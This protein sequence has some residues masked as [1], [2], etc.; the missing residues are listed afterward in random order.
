MSRLANDVAFLPTAS[1]CGKIR[2]DFLNLTAL[3][4]GSRF[5]RRLVRPGGCQYDLERDRLAQLKE[6]LQQ[7]LVELEQ[8]ASWLWDASSVRSRFESTGTVFAK[9]A[10]EIGLVGPA[11]RACGSC[12]KAAR[13]FFRTLARRWPSSMRLAPQ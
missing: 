2:G 11:A 9:Q 7:A 4:C 6:R 8:A 1:A 5:G 12:P 3:I 13:R 10:V